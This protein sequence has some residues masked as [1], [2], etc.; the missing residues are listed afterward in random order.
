MSMWDE[1]KIFHLTR[2]NKGQTASPIVQKLE[3]VM[4]LVGDGQTR[5]KV[6]HFKDCAVPL[7]LPTEDTD[8]TNSAKTYY[9]GGILTQGYGGHV[10]WPN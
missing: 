5:G 8:P 6:T 1:R 9:Q 2:K 10:S 3:A 4:I 7:S